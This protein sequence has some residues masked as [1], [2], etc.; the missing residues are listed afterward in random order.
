MT[1]TSRPRMIGMTSSRRASGL[2]AGLA[3]L[4]GPPTRRHSGLLGTLICQKRLRCDLSHV[5]QSRS[6]AVT[7]HEIA[8][9]YRCWDSVSDLE[10]ATLGALER[11]GADR[12]EDDPFTN[13]VPV[14]IAAR[15][16]TLECS[17]ERRAGSFVRE[18]MDVAAFRGSVGGKVDRDNVP[19]L[20]HFHLIEDANRADTPL[21]RETSR[22]KS[23]LG[24]R[25]SPRQ[26]LRGC[27][28]FP[29]MAGRSIL[30]VASG[31]R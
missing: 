28:R 27:R 15:L 4:L 25:G 1:R 9:T 24:A 31:S 19:G 23:P 18:R 29:P 2:R 26:S 16:I 30:Y 17:S 13:S 8:I 21:G 12:I 22:P 11:G 5:D 10:R 3:P 7:R 6:D 14:T 20:V